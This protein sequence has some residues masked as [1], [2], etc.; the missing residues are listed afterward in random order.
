MKVMNLCMAMF[1]TVLFLSSCVASAPNKR[2][3]ADISKVNVTAKEFGVGEFMSS[4]RTIL[5]IVIDNVTGA[6]YELIDSIAKEG[7]KKIHI[8]FYRSK[9]LDGEDIEQATE[10]VQELCSVMAKNSTLPKIVKTSWYNKETDK[11]SCLLF[12]KDNYR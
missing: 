9:V 11:V 12:K 7:N 5:T 2:V 4:E 1:V 8:G 3:S 10:R 6:Q